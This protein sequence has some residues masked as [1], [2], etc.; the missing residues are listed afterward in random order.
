MVHKF[1]QWPVWTLGIWNGKNPTSFL[2]DTKWTL[3]NKIQCIWFYTCKDAH[4]VFRKQRLTKPICQNIDKSQRYVLGRKGS[5]HILTL[6][7]ASVTKISILVLKQVTRRNPFKK[8]NLFKCI[9]Y[10]YQ[11]KSNPHVT[12]TTFCIWTASR[13]KFKCQTWFKKDKQLILHNNNH[14]E[15]IWQETYAWKWEIL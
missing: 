6:T 10:V 15:K 7:K 4:F 1:L 5:A 3:T 13:G 12:K 14:L 8:Q 2:C 11:G 9:R